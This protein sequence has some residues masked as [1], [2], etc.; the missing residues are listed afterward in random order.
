MNVGDLVLAVPHD[1]TDAP[2]AATRA[3]QGRI[4]I[5]QVTQR[6]EYADR[7]GDGRC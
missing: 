7:P 5:P 1:D 2:A 6:L 3:L 4:K